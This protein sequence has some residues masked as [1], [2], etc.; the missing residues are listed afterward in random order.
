MRAIRELHRV[1]RQTLRRVA[2]I[3]IGDPDRVPGVTIVHHQVAALD[4]GHHTCGI[5]ARP[6][7]H[8]VMVLRGFD[9]DQTV[10][11]VANLELVRIRPNA[12]RQHVVAGA[13]GDEVIALQTRNPVAH[14]RAAQGLAAR[15]AGQIE[16][17]LQQFA[18][19]AEIAVFEQD[20]A[21]RGAAKRIVR[22]ETGEADHI[23]RR[24]QAHFH[25]AVR[26]RQMQFAE[27]DADA[28][29]QPVGA[30]V[31]DREQAVAT[32][33]DEGVV[34][35]PA[36]HPV[37]AGARVDHIVA[38]AR[39]DYVIAGAAENSVVPGAAG[40]HIIPRS[41]VKRIS[42]RTADQ[43]IV[44]GGT[45]ITAR[46]AGR[47]EQVAGL[48]IGH[49]IVAAMRSFAARQLETIRM[50]E[51]RHR[52]GS[53]G[54]RKRTQVL[55]HQT[56][57]IKDAHLSIGID[58]LHAPGGCVLKRATTS[59]I[60]PRQID[61]PAHAAIERQREHAVR[62]AIRGH[63]RQT[64]AYAERNRVA[65]TSTSAVAVRDNRVMA[66]TA[67]EHEGVDAVAASE[68]IV[69]G[70]AADYVV[71]LPAE[72]GIV[73]A[74]GTDDVRAVAAIHQIVVGARHD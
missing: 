74:A 44:P 49:R 16:T 63:V 21:E 27:A 57:Q 66:V 23:S 62:A 26:L 3:K 32:M 40:D 67:V 9:I 37:D 10:L 33:V 19:G 55:C 4:V 35:F 64:H 73:T 50:C 2:E 71:S 51:Q 48:R 70:L 72:Y 14:R 8:R 52:M 53:V 46:I 1:E 41:A 45:Q 25:E 12:A 22:I 38:V 47:A 61:A 24:A 20:V 42:I 54:A 11:P 43:H 28:E 65:R 29:A 15:C 56:A 58:E 7:A 36:A 60:E 18:V 68:R 31:L 59:R 69:A 6:E 30:K 34:A 13:A 5:D 39:V 17:F